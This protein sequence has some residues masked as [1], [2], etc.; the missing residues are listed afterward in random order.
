MS[1]A[2]DDLGVDL[3]IPPHAEQLRDPPCILAVFTVIA[4]SAAL[5]CRL[6]S[7]TTR[8]NESRV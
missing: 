1:W 2:G 4:E 7:K 3:T 5:T 8:S 6:S